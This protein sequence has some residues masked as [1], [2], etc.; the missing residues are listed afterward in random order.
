MKPSSF[1]DI[2][3]IE[4]YLD[5]LKVC[6]QEA[7]VILF[8]RVRVLKGESSALRAFFELNRIQ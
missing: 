3:L 4:A 8:A 2:A 5:F 7:F 6:M 1:C